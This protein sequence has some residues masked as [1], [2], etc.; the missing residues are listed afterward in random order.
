MMKII[1]M[2]M[3]KVFEWKS[4]ERTVFELKYYWEIKTKCLWKG[5]ECLEI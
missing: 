3:I 5:L 4:I 1:E 2:M